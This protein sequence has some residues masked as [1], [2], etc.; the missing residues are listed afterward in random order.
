MPSFPIPHLPYFVLFEVMKAFLDHV[1]DD[2]SAYIVANYEALLQS[3]TKSIETY[4]Q[5]RTPAGNAYK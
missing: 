1:G 4:C 3:G 5:M 2:A